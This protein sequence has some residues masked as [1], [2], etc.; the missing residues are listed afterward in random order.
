MK[1]KL[2]CIIMMLV[3][4]TSSAQYVKLGDLNHDNQVNITDIMT[5]WTSS[6]TDIHHSLFLLWKLPCK[7]VALPS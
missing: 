1:K 6:C 5:W 4:L 3:S 2:S 7:L